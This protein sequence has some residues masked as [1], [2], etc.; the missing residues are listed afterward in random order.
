[1]ERTRSLAIDVARGLA[2]ILMIQ[3]HAYDGYVRA[4]LRSSFAYLC[5]RF[6]AVLPLPT[7]LLLAGT[8]LALRAASAVKRGESASVVRAEFV[9]RGFEI[10]AVGY[11]LN[12]VL[13]V[14]EGA[15]D[16]ETYLRVDVLHAIGFSIVLASTL[17]GNGSAPP[18]GRRLVVVGVGLVLAMSAAVL[19]LT[20]LARTTRTTT[21]PLGYLVGIFVEVPHVTRMPVVPL[22]AF[23]GVGLVFGAI[24][25]E[26]PRSRTFYA[27]VAVVSAA[28]AVASFLAMN[29]VVARVGGRFDRTHPAI[30]LNIV[31][32][33]ARSVALVSLV[34][35][36]DPR[37]S[38]GVARGLAL[39]GRH[40]LLAYAVHLPFVYGRIP[41]PIARSCSMPEA[42]LALALVLA[43]T[44]LVVFLRERIERRLRDSAI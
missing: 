18:S 27:L 7:F 35:A 30:L 13:G 15:T 32:L 20:K 40:S 6:L 22:A 12:L 36:I 38:S 19:P 10:V 24:V 16:V 17:V 29:A 2:V 43:L 3:T 26:R 23:L 11:L 42:S 33:A 34:L 25:L 44:G 14:L 5:T 4:D 1:V 41:R 31:E 39:L 9:R 8:G 37:S 21:G 28:V